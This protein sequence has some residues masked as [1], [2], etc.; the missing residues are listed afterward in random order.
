M[1]GSRKQFATAL[2]LAVALG[3]AVAC[4]GAR[5]TLASNDDVARKAE[6][7]RSV[8]RANLEYV[9]GYAKA[10]GGVPAGRQTIAA[11]TMAFYAERYGKAS[12]T[13]RAMSASMPAFVAD[14]GLSISADQPVPEYLSNLRTRVTELATAS[15]NTEDLRK[16]LRD[17]QASV[18]NESWGS[19]QKS[20]AISYLVLL[21][22]TIAY[23]DAH[24]D[25]RGASDGEMNAAG[26]P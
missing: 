26:L 21:E 12:S 10:R 13:Y 9:E 22:E 23:L 25:A 20:N 11:G 4:D 15:G 8:Y 2:V 24:P 6:E 3:G 5:P 7:L 1:I 16:G 19:D 17:L 14:G 18:L